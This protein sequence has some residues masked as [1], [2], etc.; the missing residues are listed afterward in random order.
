MNRYNRE[1]RKRNYENKKCS[2]CGS[3]NDR[4]PKKICSVCSQKTSS[5]NNIRRDIL[6]NVSLCPDC[7]NEN[8]TGKYYCRSCA[9]KRAEKYH[10]MKNADGLHLRL[11]VSLY[12]GMYKRA[13][14]EIIKNNLGGEKS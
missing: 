11:I 12:V 4:Y 1:Y 10:V 13:I 3:E 5:Y 6:K 8:D 14:D 7:G 9:K 2:R